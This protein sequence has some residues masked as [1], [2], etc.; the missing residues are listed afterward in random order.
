MAQLRA[1]AKESQQEFMESF[2]EKVQVGELSDSDDE[3]EKH[4][5]NPDQSKADTFKVV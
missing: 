2:E 5:F 3:R 4:V 1:R